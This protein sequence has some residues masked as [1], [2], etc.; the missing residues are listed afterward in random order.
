MTIEER[1]L[2]S[3][4]YVWY[5]NVYGKSFSFYANYITVNVLLQLAYK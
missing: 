1:N 3:I 2:S 4:A 5:C